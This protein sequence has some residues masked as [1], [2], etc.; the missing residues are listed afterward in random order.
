MHNELFSFIKKS[1]TAF[2]AVAEIAKT[3]ENSGYSRLN[4]NEE[5][6]LENNG[7]Y[8][9]VRGGASI[10]A[11]RAKNNG[12]GFMTVATHSD[13]PC[14]AVKSNA[15]KEG[16]YSRLSVEGYGGMINYSWLDRPL[17]VAGRV[18]VKTESGMEERLVNIDENLLCI[19]SVAIHFNRTVNEGIKLNPAVDMLPLYSGN[20]EKDLVCEIA[21]AVNAKKEDVLGFDL[22]AYNRDEGTLFG[23]ENEFI[24]CPRLDNL[25]CTYS[26]LKAFL[27]ASDNEETVPVLAVFDNEE[28][29]SQTSHGAYSTFLSDTLYRI[30]GNR[31]QYLK[32]LA[33]SF[34]V[35]ADNA[36]AFHPNHPELS[37]CD[38]APVLNE[39]VVIKRTAS[40]RYATDGA[41]MAFFM[42]ICRRANA[43]TQVFHNRS[44]LAGGSTLGAITDGTVS[45]PTVDIGF[46]QLAMHSAN[47]TAAVADVT[48]MTEALTAF[49]STAIIQK[50]DIIELKKN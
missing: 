5:W 13:S 43:K 3:L 11:F 38:N 34:T 45:V 10:I 47:E 14:F 41:S 27:G 30:A 4:E 1:P 21:K 40:R 48:A 39:G 15:Q 29:G 2:H 12:S 9:V 46:A 23:A 44:D 7:K 36:H 25:E 16:K 37:D 6:L 22:Y 17:S 50:G 19:P 26:A 24:L 32:M 35:S 28:I 20:K 8:F 49:Y 18:S 31:A 33:N 42:E